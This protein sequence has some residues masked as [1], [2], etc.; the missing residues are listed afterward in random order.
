MYIAMNRFKVIKGREAEFEEVWRSRESYLS[1]LKGFVSFS[2]LR[3]PEQ[4]DHTLMSSHTVWEKH[5]DFEAW[6]KS[7]QFRMAH[8]NAGNGRKLPL[9]GHPNFEGFHV[10][11]HETNPGR[12]AA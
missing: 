12:A 1:Q 2:L 11:L 9:L 6:T 3:G 4:E 5:Q 8:A 10:V 7:E